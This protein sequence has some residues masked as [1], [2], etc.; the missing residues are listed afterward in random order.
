M[1]ASCC[2]NYINFFIKIRHNI[3]TKQLIFNS[4]LL[5]VSACQKAITRQIQYLKNSLIVYLPDDGFL[6]S[7]NL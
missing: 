5:H 6:K 4:I 3:T 1:D 7:R 2:V